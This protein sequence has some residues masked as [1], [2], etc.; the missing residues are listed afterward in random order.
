[1]EMNMSMCLYWSKECYFVLEQ[2][3]SKTV[4]T[5]I[6]GCFVSALMAFVSMA[7]KQL[8]QLIILR[9]GGEKGL[10]AVGGTERLN[11]SH[12]QNEYRSGSDVA[13]KL[14]LCVYYFYYSLMHILIM[15]LI[16]TMNGFVILS[17]VLGMTLGYVLFEQK[18][19][20]MDNLAEELPVNCGA[21]S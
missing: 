9:F 19:R 12:D 15:L 13:L 10:E 5:F 20:K 11:Q 21:C 7:S 16:M 1:M 14:W 3:E 8:K 17:M 2:L 4:G 6:L 18:E